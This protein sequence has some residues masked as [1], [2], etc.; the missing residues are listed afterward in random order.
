[1]QIIVPRRSILF[2]AVL[3]SAIIVMGLA[4][5]YLPQAHI[6]VSPLV[7]SRTIDQEIILSSSANEPDFVHFILPTKV[8]HREVK[9]SQLFEQSTTNKF[10]DFA[11]GEVILF[12]SQEDEQR[13]LPKTHLRHEESG[14]FFL[15]DAAVVIPPQGEIKVTVTA[16]EKGETG[17]VAAGRWL[18]DK[19]PASLQSR[20]YGE[21]SVP[22]GGGMAAETPLTEAE[23][24]QAKEKILAGARS[25]LA[26]ELTVAAGGAHIRDDLVLYSDEVTEA[27][28]E[29]GSRASQFTVTTSMAARA[30]LVDE[31]DLLSLTLLTLRQSAGAEEEFI[32]FAPDSFKVVIQRSDFERGEAVVLGT[33][34]GSFASKIGSAVFGGENLAG[35]GES[36]VREVLQRQ[37]GIGE[38]KV[39]FSPFWVRTVPARKGAVEI[40][41]TSNQ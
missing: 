5:V 40:S 36:E 12:N 18:V 39:N 21:S 22:F 6:T 8:V 17:N 34:T 32:A 14:V 9:E 29:T 11:R 25:R 7:K 10:E 16:R 27:S 20:V 1:M 31:N 38:V 37:T 33:L 15:T 19:L 3:I 30:F 41:A 35:L 23:L 4:Y 24:E 28:V 13:L 2:L 26:G